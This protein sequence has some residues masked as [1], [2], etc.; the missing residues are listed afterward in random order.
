MS[1]TQTILVFEE[2]PDRLSYL[3]IDGDLTRFEGVYIELDSQEDEKL[4][5]ELS[6]LIYDDNGFKHKRFETFPVEIFR[7]NPDTTAVVTCGILL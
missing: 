1:I 7:Q 3:V 4:Q 5:E 6:A 2:I